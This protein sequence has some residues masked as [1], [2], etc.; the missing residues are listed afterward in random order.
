[1]TNA[2]GVGP[3]IANSSTKEICKRVRAPGGPTFKTRTA[4][5]NH[6]RP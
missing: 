1:M 5:E 3:K 6:Q 4:I 2:E